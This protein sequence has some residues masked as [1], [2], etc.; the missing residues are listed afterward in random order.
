MHLQNKDGAVRKVV[1]LHLQPCYK[2]EVEFISLLGER[3]ELTHID[4]QGQ[5]ETAVSHIKNY[6]AQVDA[7]AIVG[8]THH[9]Q[10][11][12][13]KIEH[14]ES[15][16]L[17]TAAQTTPVLDGTGILHAIERWAVRLVDEIEPGIWSQKKVLMT[18]GLN[19]GGMA[20]SFQAYTSDIHYADPLVYFDL[21]SIPAIGSKES[22]AAVAEPTIKQLKTLPYHTLFPYPS[23]QTN[24]P[25]HSNKPI[26]EAQVIAGDIGAIR[27]IISSD[28]TGKTV[29][30]THVSK[31]EVKALRQQKLSILVT[32]FPN[33]SHD[34]RKFAHHAPATVEA[35]L[36][37][38]QPASEQ[39]LNED[40]YLT[41]LADIRW[42][43]TIRYLQPE[44]ARTSK[45]AYVTQ[46]ANIAH[47]QQTYGWTSYL[48]KGLL[49][50]TAAHI[51]PVF[52]GRVREIT[53]TQT[54]QNAEASLLMLGGTPD[55]FAQRDTNFVYRRLLRAARM[56]EQLGARLMGVSAFSDAMGEAS[57]L[58]SH[59][60]G[61]AITSGRSL[62]A[63]ATI[64]AAQA[65]VL[66]MSEHTD[67]RD[68]TV[69]VTQA[70][71]K[72]M[73]ACIR[74]LAP[75]CPRLTLVDSRP[76]QLIA[77]KKQ[78]EQENP[79]A[80][81]TI[82][83]SAADAINHA[84]L[85]LTMMPTSTQNTGERP[86]E[87]TLCQPGAVICDF[88]RPTTFPIEE[89]QLRPDILIIHAGKF[90]MPG[91]PKFEFDFGL[92]DRLIHPSFVEAAVLAIEERFQDFSVGN[93]L[94]VEKLRE[95][96]TLTHK[97]GFVMDGLRSYDQI[98]SKQEIE[99]RRQEAEKLKQNPEQ[100]TDLVRVNR[101]AL[102]EIEKTSIL[103][104]ISRGGGTVIVAGLGVF[105]IIAGI[106]G[107]LFSRRKNSD[108]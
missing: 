16:P 61:I 57:E 5:I 29:V 108:V 65:A 15:G 33:L 77:L 56:A 17:F 90:R 27:Q 93:E 18:P 12:T 28:L 11:G 31:E 38:L 20:E 37:A 76:E 45:F 102:Q 44:E 46:P 49:K 3:I 91:E 10:L 55:E 48:P 41:Q 70:S 80:Q 58:V 82:S 103:P 71:N 32:L 60:T 1:I 73:A 39:P 13:E 24:Q 4:C 75:K 62:S 30:T 25:P 35:C 94:S 23:L 26:T 64:E 9:I 21:P 63:V 87:L 54:E 96:I 78:I 2:P 81:I 67:L 69:A 51:P 98:L 7:I 53:S 14:L 101:Q 8:A 92:P 47:L 89:A 66:Q 99:E 105:A 106:A 74:Y 34:T 97:H 83:T 42:Q 72:S 68:V 107:W 50:R 59:K 19:H 43:P 84:D 85:I 40:S 36:A 52:V 95:I 104:T 100:M 22:L 6:D 79:N 88:S 86:F